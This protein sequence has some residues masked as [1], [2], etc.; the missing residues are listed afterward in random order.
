M[1]HLK[2]SLTFDFHLSITITAWVVSLGPF[3][4]KFWVD[5]SPRWVKPSKFLGRDFKNE[6]HTSG[7]P[8]FWIPSF[9]RKWYMKH[10]FGPFL[11]QLWFNDVTAGVKTAI[12]SEN[13][14]RNKLLTLKFH[15]IFISIFLSTSLRDIQ[16]RSF[17]T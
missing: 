16:P 14:L 10:K 17:F 12:F 9:Y 13:D 7:L 2:V 5:T 6:Y 15:Q 11:I 8:Y 1:S 3:S 4:S